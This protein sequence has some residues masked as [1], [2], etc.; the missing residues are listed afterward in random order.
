M[1]KTIL[2]KSTRRRNVRGF[3]LIEVMIS[4]AILSGALLVLF[5]FHARAVSVNG[6]AKKMTDCT[7]L[8]QAQMERLISFPWEGSSTPTEYL[9]DV[10]GTDTTTDSDPWVF[11]E[12]PD[13]GSEPNLKTANDNPFN[14]AKR[15]LVT[16]DTEV[17]DS[18][19]TWM[20]IRVRC[21][22]WDSE[23]KV[24]KG[25]TIGSYKFRDR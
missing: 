18:D 2:S 3:T 16:W 10:N 6:H 21:Q 7:Y 8:A 20:R 24:Y 14:G 13:A 4:A 19:N 17:M 9:E 5:G 12:Q 25:T 11:L 23:F 15:Y 22:Y 1:M